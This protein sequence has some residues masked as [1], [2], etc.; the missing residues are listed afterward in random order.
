L[1]WPGEND[2]ENLQ[3]L[4]DLADECGLQDWM[5]FPTGDEATAFLSL[6]HDQL[7]RRYCLTTAEWSV[8]RWA[9]DKRLTYR[10][11]GELGVPVPLTGYPALTG[12]PYS[13]PFPA[14][15]K[16]AVKLGMDRLSIEKAWRVDG[17]DE[18]AAR[19]HDAAVVHAPATL[20]VQELIPGAGDDQF[21][22]AGLCVNGEPL[23]SLVTKRLRQYPMDFGRSSTYVVTI[24]D[25]RVET[26]AVRVIRHLKLSGLVEVEFKRDP[27][28]GEYKL[29]DVNARIWGWH[30]IARGAGV[31]FPYL[32]WRLLTGSPVARRRAP[33][34]LTWMRLSTDLAASIPA[35]GNGRLSLSDYLPTL[36]GRHERA[37]FAWDDA[38]PGLLDAPLAAAQA[39][40][41]RLREPQRQ[42][43][44][45]HELA[46][47]RLSVAVHRRRVPTQTTTRSAG[48]A[49]EEVGQLDGEDVVVISGH[50]VPGRLDVDVTRS[51]YEGQQFGGTLG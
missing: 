8:F 24:D 49:I 40:T 39:V 3:F 42:P 34:G 6:R 43:I 9:F 37:V 16:P 38:M 36:I 29:L 44:T 11:A 48:E 27:R 12:V 19:L 28:D 46:R 1:V 15:V 10:M 41:I 51:G 31:D 33:A 2:E 30:T 23:V 47:S 26:L 45:D 21:S 5:I 7:S 4:L 17:S 22:F 13:G 32:Q 18:L 14:I 25:P 50:H 35:I 20:M